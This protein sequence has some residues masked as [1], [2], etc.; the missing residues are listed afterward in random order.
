MIWGVPGTGFPLSSPHF[1]V[2]KKLLLE[3]TSRF[4]KIDLTEC[5]PL[6]S[7]MHRETDDTNK[8]VTF[9]RSWS[10]LSSWP[11]RILKLE[12]GLGWLFCFHLRRFLLDS[13]FY[14]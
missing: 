2:M 9:W 8:R 7:W 11:H 6:T 5:L 12:E 13:E 3:F 4:E 14:I 10:C 1:S